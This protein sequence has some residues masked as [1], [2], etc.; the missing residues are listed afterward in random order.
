MFIYIDSRDRKNFVYCVNCHFRHPTS[1][2]FIRTKKANLGQPLL[3]AVSSRYG[4]VEDDS[5]GVI[6]EDMFVLGKNQK[7]TTVQ[8]VGAQAVNVKQR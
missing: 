1:G 7:K 2:S 8:I 6:T 3:E 4:L 5:A